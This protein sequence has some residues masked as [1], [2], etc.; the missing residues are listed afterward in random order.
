LQ[1]VF[2]SG[3]GTGTA[4]GSGQVTNVGLGLGSA[5][6]NSSF[7]SFG[8]SSAFMVGPGGLGAGGVMDFDTSGSHVGEG[9]VVGVGTSN[10]GGTTLATGTGG[11]MGGYNPAMGMLFGGGGSNGTL[12][13]T[14]DTTGTTGLGMASGSS[15][16]AGSTSGGGSGFGTFNDFIAGG[17]GDGSASGNAV[18]TG[19]GMMGGGFT[20]TGN[21]TNANFAD[22]GWGSIP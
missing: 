8:S 2:G 17:F 12:D 22:F 4:T 16:G 20:G 5:Q 7:D 15:T 1:L 14:S 13:I 9:N 19:F 10:F 6:G 21:V 18:G 11:F 3:Y